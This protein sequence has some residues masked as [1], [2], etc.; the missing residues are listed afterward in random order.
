[1]SS[2]PTKCGEPDGTHSRLRRRHSA[3][4]GDKFSSGNQPTEPAQLFTLRQVLTNVWQD[5]CWL[6]TAGLVHLGIAVG[7]WVVGITG[8]H[9][10][11]TIYSYWQMVCALTPVVVAIQRCIQPKLKRH[12]S[13]MTNGG[14][15]ATSVVE[16]SVNGGTQGDRLWVPLE[17]LTALPYGWS[18]LPMLLAFTQLL[19]LV[20]IAVHGL[21]HHNHHHAMVP[22]QSLPFQTATGSVYLPVHGLSWGGLMLPLSLCWTILWAQYARSSVY[23]V[24]TGISSPDKN[25]ASKVWYRFGGNLSET[26]VIITGVSL[27][28]VQ[29]LKPYVF[30][31]PKD[32]HMALSITLLMVCTTFPTLKRLATLLLQAAPAEVY[33]RVVQELADISTWKDVVGY[34]N[35]HL[36]A[37][38]TDELVGTVEFRVLGLGQPPGDLLPRIQSKLAPWVTHLT[39]QFLMVNPSSESAYPTLSP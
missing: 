2:S 7:V 35:F 9:L 20:F 31:A 26:G 23:N 18:R 25:Q 19:F 13:T 14:N 30:F 15:L 28:L 22:N 17:T 39:V 6:L 38:T 27:V 16:P 4:R 5:Q 1:M 34:R 24:R 21:V 8:E 37:T 36:W 12:R 11:T 32:F 3:S 33:Q 10:S 29:W